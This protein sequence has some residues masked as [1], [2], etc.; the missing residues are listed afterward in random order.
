MIKNFFL[1][2]WALAL[3]ATLSKAQVSSVTGQ[4]LQDNNLLLNPGFESGIGKW[5]NS[6]G[7]F[8][9]DY[10]VFVQG[11]ASGKVVLS[12]QAMDFYQDS[13]LFASQLADGMQAILTVKIK[14]K[15]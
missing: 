8:T 14:N 5:T 10:F 1:F 4:Y 3:F 7:T 6:A 2:F 9:A 15:I 11:K 13:T 12:S